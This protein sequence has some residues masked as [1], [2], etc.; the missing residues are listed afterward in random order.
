[1]FYRLRMSGVVLYGDDGDRC[2]VKCNFL[3]QRRLR[4][5]RSLKKVTVFQKGT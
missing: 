2:G 1:M 5:I 4:K 3:T